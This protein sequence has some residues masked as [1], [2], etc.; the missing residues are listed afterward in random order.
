MATFQEL[1]DPRCDL[2]RAT[3]CVRGSTLIELRHWVTRR[4]TGGTWRMGS[5][6]MK[7]MGSWII[8]IVDL[9]FCRILIVRIESIYCK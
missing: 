6:Q 4:V 1:V 7:H 3:S 9:F 5:F 8:Q 2:N